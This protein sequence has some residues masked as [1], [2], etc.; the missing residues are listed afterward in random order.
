MADPVL[1]LDANSLNIYAE[2]KSWVDGQNAQVLQTIKDSET[3]SIESLEAV[4]MTANCSSEQLRKIR[5]YQDRQN[6]INQELEDLKRKTDTRDDMMKFYEK[7][8][9]AEQNKLE[10]NLLKAAV[11]GRDNVAKRMKAESLER[12]INFRRVIL[13]CYHS[14]PSLG[15]NQRRSKNRH[16][17]EI[18]K[19]EAEYT[20]AKEEF[21]LRVFTAEA[22]AGVE[23]D[24]RA[25]KTDDEIKREFLQASF[26]EQTLEAS[27]V[28]ANLGTCFHNMELIRRAK[29]LESRVSADVYA[30]VKA[31]LEAVR[32][33]DNVVDSVLW[34]YGLRIDFDTLQLKEIREDDEEFEKKRRAYLSNGALRFNHAIRTYNQ[35]G[36]NA[37]Q[38]DPM[39]TRIEENLR[40]F[41]A[42][43]RMG[44]L[45]NVKLRIMKS[46]TRRVD[47]SDS[48]G[49]GDTIKA[50]EE[51]YQ[52][53]Q[54]H[55]AVKK[56]LMYIFRKLRAILGN[57]NQAFT[58]LEEFIKEYVNENRVPY[59]SRRESEEKEAK[60]LTALKKALI[61]VH[62]SARD[63]GSRYAAL[64]YG[65][66][67][68]ES[69]GYLE[70]P[71]GEIHIIKDEKIGLRRKEE[72]AKANELKYKDCRDMPL[73]SHRPN[74]KDVAQGKLGDCYLLAGL[75]SVVDQNAE[76]IMNLM[77][78]NGDGTVT[79][80]FKRSEIEGTGDSQRTVYKPC[81]VTVE[82]TIPVLK[83]DGQD[84]FSRGALWVK[85]IEKAY[86]ASGLHLLGK[87]NKK[88]SKEHKDPLQ[89]QDFWM[90]VQRGEQNLDYDDIRSGKT[91]EI[92]SMLLGKEETRSY[93]DQN[94]VDHIADR[95]GSLLP[96]IMEPTW[97][98]DPTRR[99]GNDRADS[100]VYEFLAKRHNGA[101]LADKFV[102]LKKPVQG[103]PDFDTLRDEYKDGKKQL[104]KYIRSCMIHLDIINT[105][106][107]KLQPNFM[108]LNSETEIIHLYEKINDMFVHYKQAIG[109]GGSSLSDEDKMID[110]VRKNYATEEFKQSFQKISRRQFRDTVNILK[111]R[112][113]NRFVKEQQ[114]GQAGAGQ[115]Q[116]SYYIAKER[117]LYERIN[118]ALA[119]GTYVG[120]GTRKLSDEKTG[121]NGESEAG[122]LVGTHAYSIINTRRKTIGSTERLFFVV[123]NPWAEKGV[124]YDVDAA[125]IH[126]RAVRGIPD[127][128]KEE[129]VFLLEL[130][131]FAEVVRHWD[132]VP[133]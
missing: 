105:L 75:I 65:L 1:Q 58:S 24:R 79:V 103:D 124:V 80:C 107:Q 123:M 96:P 129:G 119:T 54:E 130:K 48:V 31:K 88:R 51:D 109:K 26:S 25:Q 6:R 36:Q 4:D 52:G 34:E 16:E 69:S 120:F 117:K 9:Q 33:Y 35:G 56:R 106:I 44:R 37:R 72:P 78:D 50:A 22:F 30:P 27:Y 116:G 71:P 84:A 132:A 13:N 77:K 104:G 28:V 59:I 3:F 121:L 42:E 43:L 55:I 90:S 68:E 112:H 122:G 81:Y 125:D 40:A 49:A 93:L 97:G 18:A 76:A 85:M 113:L 114:S 127:G 38:Q 100:I 115:A 131:K 128:E 102:K 20:K 133:A 61:E 2:A 92:M 46:L 74:I 62:K 53:K 5:D 73:F 99:Y 66:L 7:S 29:E 45:T 67:T 63:I 14:M 89:Y 98:P 70:V 126:E 118:S 19:E 32:E 21:N 57:G 17:A 23:A 60:A 15:W 82:K 101:D 87:I 10:L 111:C 12:I 39:R 47:T 86:A 64:L 108:E 94:R 83:S 8:I 110:G 11:L 91:G 95:M 41:E